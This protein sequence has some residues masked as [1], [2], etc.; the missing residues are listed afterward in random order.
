MRLQPLL[1]R[2]WARL[3]AVALVFCISFMGVAPAIAGNITG[4]YRQDTLTM[5]EDLTVL[6]QATEDTPEVAEVRTKAR[7]NI[8]DYVARYR[9]DAKFKGLRSFT[10]MQTALNSLAG[11]YS[12]YGNRPLSPKLKKRLAQ[13]FRQVEVALKRGL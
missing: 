9:R 7:T 2:F 3:L 10:T 1:S 4:N 12:S 11:F 5:L 8:N 6:V 13:E